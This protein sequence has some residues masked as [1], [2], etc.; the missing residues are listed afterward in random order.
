V[1][2]LVPTWLFVPGL[3]AAALRGL[4]R[5]ARWAAGLLLLVPW[6]TA[7]ASLWADIDRPAPLRPLAQSLERRG[8]RGIVAETP[9]ALMVANLTSGRVGALEFGA[10]WPRLHDRY[11]GRF[12]PGAP[13]ICVN[14][15]TLTWFPGE[16]R[17][18]SL[19]QR[20]GQRL[21]ELARLDPGRV[22]RIETIDHFDIWQADLPLTTVLSR[23]PVL[24]PPGQRSAKLSAVPPLHH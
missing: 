3:L 15:T 4:P 17:D 11:A 10:R 20:F 12:T 16:A 9:V 19:Q 8:V 22:R 2:Y 21:D 1:R 23:H 14:D 18:G 5:P 13:V 7:E 24:L 6:A